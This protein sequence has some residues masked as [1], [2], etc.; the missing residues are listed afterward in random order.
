MIPIT[1]QTS[2]LLGRIQDIVT[3]PD[4][5]D[6]ALELMARQINASKAALVR[7]GSDR[8][9]D[10]TLGS[11][12]ME[13]DLITHM[14]SER[15][16]PEL[17]QADEAH[18][19]AGTVSTDTDSR[20]DAIR[21]DGGLYKNLLQPNDIEHTLIGVICTDDEQHILFWLHRGAEAGPFRSSDRRIVDSLMPHWQRTI[22]QKLSFDFRHTALV[23]ASMVIDQAPFGLFMLDRD[24]HVLRANRAAEG[25]IQADDGIAVKDRSLFFGDRETRNQYAEL[26]A[27]ARRNDKELDADLP[28]FT[29]QKTAGNGT[30][31]I[32]IR[33]MQLPSRRGQLSFSNVIAVYVYDTGHRSEVNASSLRALYELTD[34]EARICSLLYQSYNLPDVASKLDISINTAKTHLN[35]SYRKLGVQSQSE[36][37]RKLAAQLY[38][39]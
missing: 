26:F 16:N 6:D 9:L 17:L 21:G 39:G 7:L 13:S 5:A 23:T 36:L 2:E 31:Q 24:A 33:R 18:W 11:Y 3:D 38:V 34:A 10:V 14:L 20:T 35:R 25:F 4:G 12:G 19:T 37:V 8:R 22:R 15:H 28:P 32:G 1:K 27:V 30:Y 29:L